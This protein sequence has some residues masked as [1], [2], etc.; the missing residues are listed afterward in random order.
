MIRPHPPKV[1]RVTSSHTNCMANHNAFLWGLPQHFPKNL[2]CN[3]AT[4]MYSDIL[5]FFLG[6]TNS[7]S[8]PW[9]YIYIYIYI[10]IHTYTYIYIYIYTYIHT[11]ILKQKWE[12][13]ANLILFPIEILF[14]LKSIFTLVRILLFWPSTCCA[15]LTLQ[16]LGW[17]VAY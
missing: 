16:K 14:Y 12:W 4:W 13:E 7:T 5:N 1:F 10:Y 8:P 3:S 9:I 17:I 15:C 11:G 6:Q 2:L